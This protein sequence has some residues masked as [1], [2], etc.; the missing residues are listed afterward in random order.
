MVACR[1][2]YLDRAAE[3]QLLVELV[4]AHE[5]KLKAVVLRPVQR[6]MLVVARVSKHFDNGRW[7]A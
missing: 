3:I 7:R 5:V 2:A 4:L 6:G 1:L